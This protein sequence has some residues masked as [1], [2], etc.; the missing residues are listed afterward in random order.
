MHCG[1]FVN[2]QKERSE[3]CVLISVL[4]LAD[5]RRNVPPMLAKYSRYMGGATGEDAEQIVR[6]K[7]FKDVNEGAV[8]TNY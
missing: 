8:R 7:A 3:P 4:V 2:T 1:D 6:R 5:G